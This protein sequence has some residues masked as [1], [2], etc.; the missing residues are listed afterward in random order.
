M[1][2]ADAS[3]N[4]ALIHLTRSLFDLLGDSVLHN[5]QKIYAME[6]SYQQI[7]K[8]HGAILRAILARDS[9]QAR[10]L[11]HAHLAYVERCLRSRG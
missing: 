7:H 5:W 1:S 8:Q 6:E 10:G 9:G 4:V 2:V 3:H 11:A